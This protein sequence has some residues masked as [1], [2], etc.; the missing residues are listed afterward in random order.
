MGTTLAHMLRDDALTARIP[1]DRR[2]GLPGSWSAARSPEDQ[3]RSGPDQADAEEPAPGP[4]LV[5]K[6]ASVRDRLAAVRTSRPDSRA[7]SSPAE[8]AWLLARRLAAAGKP[9]SR[10]AL[11]SGGIK[12]S[13]E[14]LNRLARNLSAELAGVTVSPAGSDH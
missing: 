2:T 6:E 13:N 8:Q 1:G 11:R 9:V 14:A 12:G 4:P 10:R 3:A 5:S 7:E